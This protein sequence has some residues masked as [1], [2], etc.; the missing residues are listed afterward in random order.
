MSKSIKFN[1]NEE[2]PKKL[3]AEYKA[4]A[5]AIRKI[6]REIRESKIFV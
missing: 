5:K 3:Y 4:K 2:N 1:K 6:M